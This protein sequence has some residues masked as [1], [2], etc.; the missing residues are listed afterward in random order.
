M[1]F[2]AQYNKRLEETEDKTAEELTVM[3]VG[4]LDPK[5]HL[6]MSVEELMT[7]NISQCLGS[8]LDTVV[9]PL[10]LACPLPIACCLPL[11]LVLSRCSN[12]LQGSSGV[13]S[14]NCAGCACAVAL[15]EARDQWAQSST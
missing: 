6:E 2:R 5:K 4:K 8:M 1:L 10:P 13:W 15:G 11:S 9:R 7:R 14:V 12:R 3:N